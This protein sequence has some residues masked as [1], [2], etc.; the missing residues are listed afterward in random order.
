MLITDSMDE[1]VKTWE[2]VYDRFPVYGLSD[3]SRPKSTA[4][5]LIAAVADAAGDVSAEG[6]GS[7]GHAFLCWQRVGAGRV[8]YFAAPETWRLRW[9]VT[10][11]MHHRFWGQLLRWITASN[12]GAGTDLVRLQ[13]DRTTYLTGEPVEVTAWLKDANGRPLAG[14]TIEAQAL[15]FDKAAMS[16]ELTP[17][18][19]VPGRYFG[20][21]DR[22]KAGAYQV[23]V[24]GAVVD[25][26]VPEGAADS[27]VSTITIR[28]G[29]SIEM[30]NTQ[31]NRALLD[32]VAKITGGQVIPPTAI[33][34][35]LRL[36]SFTPDVSER[37]ERTP[38][39]NRWFNLLLVLGCV[40]LEWTV[41]KG[42]GLA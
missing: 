18:E 37:V 19:E 6:A 1:S 26:L 39:W 8:A 9:R 36:V 17:D 5:T 30:L 3:Y 15:S 38:L 21:L 31:C 40:F 42:K 22:L 25:K 7:P 23:T 11:E 4:R 27:V 35:V 12:A 13:T 32:Q 2:Q 28:A 24:E 33:D 29:D 16:V 10:D 34:E 14:E 20:R 41:R